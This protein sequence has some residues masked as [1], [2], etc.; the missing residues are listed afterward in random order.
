LLCLLSV[1]VL[2]LVTAFATI[3]ASLRVVDDFHRGPVL[4]V[5]TSVVQMTEEDRTSNRNFLE[6]IVALGIAGET[7]QES[8]LEAFDVLV[9]GVVAV[10]DQKALIKQL[11]APY[12]VNADEN[13]ELSSLE[14]S[15]KTADSNADA[16]ADTLSDRAE[17]TVPMEG[18]QEEMGVDEENTDSLDYSK[19][20]GT[21]AS[22][23][24]HGMKYIG[25]S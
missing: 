14:S 10:K 17:D 15:C 23:S 21:S 8:F 4:P 3:R 24:L 18:V 12:D 9:A 20:T 7:E 2:L 5:L 11:N 16:D 13:S 6:Q 19:S 22:G 25:S 1:V